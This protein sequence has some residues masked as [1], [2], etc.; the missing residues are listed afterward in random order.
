MRVDTTSAAFVSHMESLGT[1]AV[2]PCEA[3]AMVWRIWG[4][5]PPLVLL[6]GAS[7]SWTHWIRNVRPLAARFRVLV[8][9]MPGYG[10]SDA[11]LEPHT[12]T[13]PRGEGPH[14]SD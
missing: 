10:D 13:K 11:P 8:P 4:E 7:G 6:H 14:V 2:I 1:R 9:D 12:D 5:G 3:G